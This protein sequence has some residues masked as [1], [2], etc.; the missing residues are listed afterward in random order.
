MALLQNNHWQASTLLRGVLAIVFMLWL[1]SV[2]TQYDE[3]TTTQ[4]PK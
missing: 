3:K 4:K 1:A 2:M